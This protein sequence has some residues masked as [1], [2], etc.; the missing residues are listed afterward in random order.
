[1][2]YKARVSLCNRL[3][4]S[5]AMQPCQDNFSDNFSW[6]EG[7]TTRS[8]ETSFSFFTSPISPCCEGQRML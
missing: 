5:A 3:H 7:K 8:G 6:N 2:I 1:V 4:Y